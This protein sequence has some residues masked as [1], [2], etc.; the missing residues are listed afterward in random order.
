MGLAL[1]ALTLVIAGVR[2]AQACRPFAGELV[3]EHM[4]H[5]S[6]V[7]FRATAPAR[8]R[9]SGAQRYAYPA[10]RIPAPIAAAHPRAAR[11]S[12]QASRSDARGRR[13]PLVTSA[14]PRRAARPAGQS[15]TEDTEVVIAAA[16]AVFHDANAPPA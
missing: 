8:P 2:S 7:S 9:R 13:D 10:R 4:R 5:G 16:S 14:P 3:R 15:Q 6:V 11:E 1:G 12:L